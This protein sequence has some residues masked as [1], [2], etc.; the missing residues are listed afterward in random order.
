MDMGMRAEERLAELNR[1]SRLE[2][3]LLHRLDKSISN[4]ELETAADDDDEEYD[5]DDESDNKSD[6]SDAVRP[7]PS[8]RQNLLE[9]VLCAGPFD[10]RSTDDVYPLW[11]NSLCSEVS[12]RSNTPISA[13]SSESFFN[14]SVDTTDS[15]RFPKFVDSTG[16]GD[17]CRWG[18]S[19]DH[20]CASPISYVPSYGSADHSRDCLCLGCCSSEEF[21]KFQV[22]VEEQLE[23]PY[24]AAQLQIRRPCYAAVS[25]VEELLGDRAGCDED[26]DCRRQSVSVDSK[27]AGYVKLDSDIYDTDTESDTS[28]IPSDVEALLTNRSIIEDDDTDISDLESLLDQD[29]ADL[30]MSPQAYAKKCSM[31]KSEAANLSM[32]AVQ[33]SEIDWAIQKLDREDLPALMRFFDLLDLGL[34]LDD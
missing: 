17:S 23:E 28:S 25:S 22:T 2:K 5:A 16:W 26:C 11:C 34:E 4:V 21:E 20:R 32:V 6:R 9:P 29:A 10:P 27:P 33:R 12:L 18:I 1:R 31:L 13:A 19:S 30:N 7:L 3:A 8:M 15:E 24:R 14:E